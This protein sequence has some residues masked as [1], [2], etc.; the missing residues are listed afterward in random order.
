MHV[1]PGVSLTHTRSLTVYICI[2]ICILRMAPIVAVVAS[3]ATTTTPMHDLL[4]TCISIIDNQLA[5]K[6]K[7]HSTSS[8]VATQGPLTVCVLRIIRSQ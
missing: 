1:S 7:T 4:P 2:Y 3:V 8:Q 5:Q 6:E